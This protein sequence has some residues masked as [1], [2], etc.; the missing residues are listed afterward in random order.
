MLPG[1]MYIFHVPQ[2][3]KRDLMTLHT[4]LTDPLT[5]VRDILGNNTMIHRFQLDVKGSTLT[6]L[7]PILPAS[8]D[9][10]SCSD[11]SVK[12]GFASVGCQGFS[13]SDNQQ[14]ESFSEK[15]QAPSNADFVNKLSLKDDDIHANIVNK[16]KGQAP[17]ADLVNKLS[18]KED[19]VHSNIVHNLYQV[20]QVVNQVNVQDVPSSQEDDHLYTEEAIDY[21][22][23]LAKE[24]VNVQDV[25]SLASMEQMN[26]SSQVIR[27]F[28]GHSMVKDN[29]T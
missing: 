8:F 29:E 21:F 4:V 5:E 25:P 17:N 18:L 19:E 1:W 26:R 28:K 11:V 12:R 9:S 22:L 15:G 27:F 6:S 3:G 13:A 24:E 10:S 20:N 7:P 23:K 2:V 16:V 14:S